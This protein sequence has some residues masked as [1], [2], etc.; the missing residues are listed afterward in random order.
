MADLA[1]IPPTDP[2]SISIPPEVTAQASQAVRRSAKRTREVFA[3]DFAQPSALHKSLQPEVAPSDPSPYDRAQKASVAARIRNEYASVRELPA[4]LAA[5]QANAQ[6]S[7]TARRK[8]PR[9]EDQASDPQMAKMIEEAGAQ[10]PSSLSQPNGTSTALVRIPG[11]T[12]STLPPNANGPTPQ[13]NT[14]STSLVRRD[15]VR[16][17]KPTWHA[18]WKLFRVIS[19]HLG[20]VRALAV[21]P[22]NT[23]FA[24][25]AGDR[26]IKIWDLA[27]GTLKLTLTGHISTVRGLAVSPRHPYLFSCAEDKMVKCWDLETNKVIRHYHGHLSGVYTLALHPTLDVL[28]TGGRDG[29]VRVWDMRTRSNIHVLSGHKATVSSIATQATDPQVMSSSL[30][31]TIRLY[32]LAAGKTMSVL[33][34]HK[35]GVRSLVTHPTEYTFASASPGQIKQ[36]LCPKGD[37]M[38]N[39]TGHNSVINSLAVNEEDVLFS[40]GD[41]GSVAFWDWKTGHRFQYEDSLA[42]PGSLDAEAGIMSSTFDKSGLRLMTG[43]ADKTIKVWKQDE[44]AT[45]ESHPL[46]W[47]PTMGRQKF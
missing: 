35:K 2:A 47:A 25:G 44:D 29:V 5:K 37:F 36:W 32:D 23:W 4:A 43:E 40:G 21:E 1:T 39:F 14:S 13:R 38:Q 46:Q 27:T 22:G 10:Q 41:N 34:H 15:T 26:T 45:P 11:T 9:A 16:Q 28:C 18:P 33:T 31:S 24:S 30:D 19:G 6:T 20:W 17:P 42:Q 7:L 12:N 3:A 8:K